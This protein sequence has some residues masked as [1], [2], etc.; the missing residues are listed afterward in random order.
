MIGTAPVEVTAKV[1]QIGVGFAS[2]PETLW[3]SVRATAMARTGLHGATPDT[4]LLV[5]A[6]PAGLLP[7]IRS[8]CQTLLFFPVPDA[9]VRD[10]ARARGPIEPG[11]LELV[12][13]LAGGSLARADAVLADLET[14][15]ARVAQLFGALESGRLAEVVEKIDR[16]EARAVFA[17][18]AAALRDRLAGRDTALAR[19][20]PP[21]VDALRALDETLRHEIF[22][23]LN[24]H[25]GLTVENALLKVAP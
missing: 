23:G 14:E 21:G 19:R 1:L 22:L 9:A 17:L 24:A 16:A 12:A 13:A 3:A 25:V 5:T 10:H 18:L 4:V 20:V 11:D 15:R 8:R 2:H 6:A 7:T